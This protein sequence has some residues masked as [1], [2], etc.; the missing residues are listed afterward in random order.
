MSGENFYGV[1]RPSRSTD[2][3][4]F[5]REE[6]LQRALDRKRESRTEGRDNNDNKGQNNDHSNTHG[7]IKHYVAPP[8][9][10]SN[11]K[12]VTARTSR[13]NFEEGLNKVMLVAQGTSI[14]KRGRGIGFYCEVCDLTFKDNLQLIDHY[15]SKQHIYTSGKTLE[16]RKKVTIE[17]VRRRIEYLH[18]KSQIE[19]GNKQ[20]QFDIKKR[21]EEFKKEEEKRNL[22]KKQNKQK[23]DEKRRRKKMEEP[24]TTT[25][26]SQDDPMRVMMG[27]AGFG[28]TKK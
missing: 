13:Q 24:K 19:E 17:D 26:S 2:D 16:R 23:M 1:S 21:I 9:A 27:F 14:G 3:G 6:A 8:D 12:K 25:D 18:K 28:S 5:N 7:N 11:A 15:N 4:R 22:I 20:Q 10:F